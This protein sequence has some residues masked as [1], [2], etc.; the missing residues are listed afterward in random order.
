MQLLLASL[1]L[2]RRNHM[3]NPSEQTLEATILA[4]IAERGPE[5]SICPSD[6]AVAVGGK[7]GD[8]W[9]ALMP[10]VRR[11]AV[12]LA[13]EGKLVILR[14]GK[15]ADPHDFRGVYRLALPRFE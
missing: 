6:A 7:A 11:I 3:T 9:G 2:R 15:V 13:E 1:L 8:Q 5:R 10:A 14:K 4:M 12:R